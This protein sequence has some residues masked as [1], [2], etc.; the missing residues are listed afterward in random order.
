MLACATPSD[1]CYS[2]IVDHRHSPADV[3]TGSV[4]GLV[5]ASLF[6]V[7]LLSRVPERQAGTKEYDQRMPLVQ[8]DDY[9]I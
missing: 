4:M 6:F 9:D 3:I 7:R 2:R 8:E 5:F 1:A